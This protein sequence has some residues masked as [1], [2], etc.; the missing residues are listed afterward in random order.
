MVTIVIFGVSIFFAFTILLLKMLYLHR[1]RD[2]FVLRFLGRCDPWTERLT[3]ATKFRTLQIIQSVR[4]LFLLRLP[5]IVSQTAKKYK[6]RLVLKLE[7]KRNLLMGRKEIT[8]KGAVSFFLKKMDEA[9]KNGHKG[10]I[11]EIL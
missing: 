8:N 10:E 4:Y 11:N 5:E 3:S 2:G 1:G 7:N 6:G 9:K